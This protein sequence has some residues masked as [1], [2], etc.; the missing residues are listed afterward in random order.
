MFLPCRYLVTSTRP[1]SMT[2]AVS[3]W[4]F[5]RMMIS[6]LLYCA[7]VSTE[8]LL[9]G[10]KNLILD[11]H[12]CQFWS[13]PGFRNNKCYFGIKSKYQTQFVR[14]DV[15]KKCGSSPSFTKSTRL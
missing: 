8:H 12:A 13:S 9:T 14:Y 11:A 10:G 6:P 7:V 4:S 3:P 1:L 5:S 15:G 2:Y